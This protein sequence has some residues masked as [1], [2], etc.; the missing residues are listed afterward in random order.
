MFDLGKKAINHQ[1]NIQRQKGQLIKSLE[2]LPH[3]LLAYTQGK[4][5]LVPKTPN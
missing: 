1:E 4:N 5:K 2:K 3:I